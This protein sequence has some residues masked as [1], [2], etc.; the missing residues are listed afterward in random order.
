M[1]V[2]LFLLSLLFLRSSS[3][4]TKTRQLR[5]SSW[6]SA[7]SRSPLPWST[8]PPTSDPVRS[9]G[10]ELKVPVLVRAQRSDWTLSECFLVQRLKSQQNPV[11]LHLREEAELG[12]APGR[13]PTNYFSKSDR[14][15]CELRTFVWWG[16]SFSW[17]MK[18]QN[19][20]FKE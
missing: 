5:T 9:E 13:A 3:R 6:R 12:P 19:L 4:W 14:W 7:S 20:K 11:L 17:Q 2:S 15:V 8:K 1:C 10:E 16:K 18:I